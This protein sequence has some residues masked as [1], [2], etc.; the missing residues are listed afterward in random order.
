MT[1]EEYLRSKGFKVRHAPGELETQCPFCGDTNKYGHLYV[2]REH[3][4]YMCHRCGE[5]GSFRNLQEQLGDKPDD[6]TAGLADKSEVWSAAVRICQDALL[7][8]QDALDY[9]RTDRGLLPATIGKYRLGW[10]PRDLIDQLHKKFSIA[11]LRYAGLLGDK[12]YPLFWDRLLIPYYSRDQVV[13]LRAKQIGGNVIQAKNTSI[14]LF[15][16]DDIRGRTEVFVA[17]GEFDA[18]YLNQVGFPTC[19]IPGAQSFQELWSMY[20]EKARRVFVVLDADEA[21]QKGALKIKSIL[22]NRTRVIDLPVPVG[23]KTTDISEFFLRDLH[24]KEDFVALV[25]AVRGQRVFMLGDALEERDKLREQEGIH[26]GFR[27]LDY[28]I[29]PGML[30]GQVA[31]VLA[32]TGVGKTALVTQFIH[33][34]SAWQPFDKS[35]T[36]PGIPVLVLSLEQTKAEI[37]E[38][39]ERIGRLYNPWADREE[40]GRWHA[41]MRVCD[42]NRIPPQDIGVIVDEF[43]EDVGEAPRVFIVDYLGYWSRAFPSSSSY[44]RVS[45]AI[46]E[47]KRIA[48]LYN[49]SVIAPHQVSRVGRSGE[50]LEMDF[51]RDSGVVEETSDFVFSLFRPHQKASEEEQVLSPYRTRADVRMEILKS[52]HGSV[53]RQVM[54][55]WAPYSLALIPRGHDLERILER[56]WKALDQQKTY[57]EVVNVL[58]GK[59]IL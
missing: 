59:A 42:E 36:G 29:H 15:G 46:M 18:M 23:E 14:K 58:K 40:L 47:L 13:A 35:T 50:R 8:N 24:T 26:L 10:A 7:S 4:A 37:A 44:E 33:N 28:A 16:V 41:N 17:E 55:L 53:G 2:N 51:A 3:G 30:P 21:G 38:R 32:K 48:K 34:L 22:K 19:A 25:D 54:M 20:F 52:R 11:D 31:T 56:E 57:E 1:P 12:D 43:I 49:V 6:A 39:L 9:L 27:D 45:E 5:S